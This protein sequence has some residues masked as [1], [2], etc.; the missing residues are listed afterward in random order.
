MKIKIAENYFDIVGKT[1][2]I[3]FAI[4]VLII[5]YPFYLLGKLFNKIKVEEI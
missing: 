5:T 1:F 2:I 3:L 4:P